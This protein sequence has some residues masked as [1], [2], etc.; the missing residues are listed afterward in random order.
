MGC[1]GRRSTPGRH[2]VR[3][4]GI[5]QHLR[6]RR[7]EGAPKIIERLVRDKGLRDE[8][9]TARALGISRKRLLGWE[10]TETQE[11]VYEYDVYGRRGKLLEVI[12][13]REPEWDDE[14]RA[15]MLALADYEAGICACG[16][17][18]SV[19]KDQANN[20]FGFEVDQCPVCAGRAQYARLQ[21][22]EDAEEDDRLEKVEAAPTDPRPAD[23][24]RVFMRMTPA[25]SVAE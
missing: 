1:A 3:G 20:H 6:G 24:R 10:S 23:G 14:S 12:T 22:K 16:F 18:E 15:E 19:A 17:H 13:V 2:Q 7:C 9:T 25:G 11:Y 5:G 21:S 8:L 4:H